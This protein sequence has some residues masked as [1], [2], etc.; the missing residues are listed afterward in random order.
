VLHP[1]APATAGYADADMDT[2]PEPQP[3]SDD[4]R[5]AYAERLVT[6][7]VTRLDAQPEPEPFPE[8]DPE[9]VPNIVFHPG[10]H[11][12]ITV[13][14]DRLA[15]V[16][17]RDRHGNTYAV[18]DCDCQRPNEYR[19]FAIRYV[20]DRPGRGVLPVRTQPYQEPHTQP[21]PDTTNPNATISATYDVDGNPVPSDDPNRSFG[22]NAAPTHPD[23]RPRNL[24]L[25]H[26]D[27]VTPIDTRHYP[28]QPGDTSGALTDAA[29]AAPL[30]SLTV[31]HSH[32]HHHDAPRVPGGPVAISHDHDHQHTGVE[33]LSRTHGTD[34]HAHAHDEPDP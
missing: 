28:Y 4:E 27:R 26:F 3:K 29:V 32:T 16:R 21:V 6:E 20:A 14:P 13:E 23:A 19:V 34:A 7:C 18:L 2:D 30:S 31:V 24:I 25:S 10:D 1:D 12:T 15:S 11:L 17:L 5:A 22:V 9:P 33:A 8:L